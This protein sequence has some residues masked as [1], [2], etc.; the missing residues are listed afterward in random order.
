MPHANPATRRKPL[1][2]VLP[3]V[4]FRQASDR[5]YRDYETLTKEEKRLD[6]KYQ[7]LVLTV[8]KVIR[9]EG[10]FSNAV[11]DGDVITLLRDAAIAAS[12]HA[13]SGTH[14]VREA[15]KATRHLIYIEKQ[16]T[17]HPEPIDKDGIQTGF[18]EPETRIPCDSF[19]ARLGAGPKG[20]N[21]V[22][23]FMVD[24]LDREFRWL[25]VLE[26]IGPENARRLESI[27]HQQGAV[28]PADR[29]WL[30][31]ITKKIRKTVTTPPPDRLRSRGT[32]I[33]NGTPHAGG[34]ASS[35]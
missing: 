12:I 17:S 30:Y 25:M 21:S 14:F 16:R 18:D 7:L 15:R 5:P 24:Q 26:T 10:M 11:H 9:F 2:D 29:S 35:L 33:G 34:K 6:R 32:P 19:G 13:L 27:L 23:T 22:E 4:R 20:V 8:N 28:S 31:R 3:I 1:R